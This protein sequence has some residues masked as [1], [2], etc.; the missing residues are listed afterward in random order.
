MN[1]VQLL[2]RSKQPKKEFAVL[3]QGNTIT[4]G[5]LVLCVDKLSIVFDQ[6]GLKPNDKIVLST[7]DARSLV[8]IAIAAYRY[9]LTVI[10]IDHTSKSTRVNSILNTSKPQAFFIDPHLKTAWAIEHNCI[11]IKKRKCREK[12]IQ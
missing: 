8:E 9:G 11:E 12:N 5:D 1:I 4:Y 7:E 3:P 2:D 6:L 10:L